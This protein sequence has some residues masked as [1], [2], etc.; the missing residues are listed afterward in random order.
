MRIFA[1]QKTADLAT[2]INPTLLRTIKPHNSPVVTSAVDRTGTLLATGSADGVVKIW[3]IRGGYVSHTF[4]GHTGIISAIRFFE[5]PPSREATKSS[6]KHD[7][8]AGQQVN[9]QIDVEMKDAWVEQTDSSA[10]LRLASG[11]EDGQIRIWDLMKRKSIASLESH[12][13]V[14]RGLD[15]ST[16]RQMLVSASRDKTLTFWDIKSW[17]S[18]KVIPVLERLESV[19]F[20]Q[21]GAFVCVGGES[22]KIRVWETETGRE[23][24][25]EQ[26][27]GGESDEIM[28]ISFQPS[29]DQLL[30]VHADQTMMFHST[31]LLSTLDSEGMVEE[32]PIIRRISG[33]HDEIIDLAYTTP[34]RE[35]LALASNSE[36]IR[37]VSL[38]GLAGERSSTAAESYFGADIATLK[39]HEDI[40]ICLDVDWS[41]CWLATGAKDNTA[42]LWLIDHANGS[43]ECFATFTGHAESLGAISLPYA[44][45]PEDSAAYSDPLSHPPSFLLTGSQDR[46]IK[47]W[48]IKK[49]VQIVDKKNPRAL[50]TRKAH[51]KDINAISTNNNSTIFASA[52]Q[53]RTVKIWSVDEGEVQGVLRGHRRGVWSVKFASKDTPSVTG[54]SGTASSSRGLILTGSGDKTVKI[55]NLADFS[56][57]RTFEGHTNSVLKVLWMPPT[58]SDEADTRGRRG[59]QV[60]SAG[61]DGL[62]KIWDANTGEVNCTLDNHTDRVWAL[63][64]NPNDNTL[65][66]GGGDSV[67]T[68]WKDT[69]SST[70]AATTAASTA[71][72]E[73]EQQ[74]QNFIH[75]GNYREAITLALQLHH[76]ARLLSLLT[77]VVNIRPPENG[78]LSGVQAVDG[79]LC[80]LADDQLFTLLLWLRDWNVNARTAQM[81]QTVL[82]VITKSYPASRLL[83]LRG[84]GKG[85][86]DI[87][88]ALEGLKVYT[89][90]HY[91]RLEELIDESYLIDY[92]LREMEELGPVD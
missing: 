21:S 58:Q 10:L 35:L 72:V 12:V 41:G 89:E 40:I 13:S 34:D 2:P 78:S 83:A 51:D 82:Y 50:Y 60:I 33:N 54:D 90:R 55:W 9:G 66:S 36:S 87:S 77:N 53:D 84:N 59:V 39:G 32:L 79:V 17:R 64:A 3:D 29:L 22:G 31:S 56:C 24:T 86:K 48:E 57:L 61:G 68:F 76:P 69:S 37:L 7:R 49:P 5:S 20:V 26:E 23:V 42:R 75:T 92:T 30:C 46:T 67:V 27:A 70:L 52:S 11:S 14:I 74:L 19:R 16:E 15:F 85:I 18:K 73:Q 25:R 81:A 28:H 63:A 38:A 65:V 80:N 6:A 4:H 1:L 43:Y 88:D 91:K 71:R 44:P 62:V 47:R 45:P 8:K